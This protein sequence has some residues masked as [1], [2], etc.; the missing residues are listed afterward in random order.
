MKL[1]LPAALLGVAAVAN[2]S[3][4]SSAYSECLLNGT[5]G[6][7]GGLIAACKDSCSETLDFCN[8]ETG[9]ATSCTSEYSTCLYSTLTLSSSCVST[10]D[11][12]RSNVSG[13]NGDS[14]HTCN[15]GLA[16][17]KQNCGVLKDL[18]ETSGLFTSSECVAQ[19]GQCL[20]S[21]TEIASGGSCVEQYDVCRSSITG[22]DGDS[23]NQCSTAMAQ[24]KDECANR[25]DA[26]NTSGAFTTAQCEAQENSCLDNYPAQHPEGSDCVSKFYTC[27]ETNNTSVCNTELAACKEECSVE[28]DAALSSGTAN[29]TRAQSQYGSCLDLYTPAASGTDCVSDYR[30]CIIMGNSSAVCGASLAQCKDS[31]GEVYDTCNTS[32][33]ENKT[34]CLQQYQLCYD[35]VKSAAYMLDDCVTRF[36][37]SK[38][39]GDSDAFSSAVLADCKQECS[40]IESTCEASGDTSEWPICQSQY[41]GCL[42]SFSFSFSSSSTPDCVTSFRESTMSNA[43]DA[44]SSALLAT[45]KN[46]CSSVY[47]TCLSSGETKYEAACLSQY[48]SCLVSFNSTLFGPG[49]DC[50]S[51]M[52]SWK[53][54][55]LP[56]N[57]VQAKMATCKNDCSDIW[58][59]CLSSGDASL[60]EPCSDLNVKCLGSSSARAVNSTSSATNGTTPSTSAIAISTGITNATS[61][62]TSDL[63]SS[64]SPRISIMAAS[65]SV[66]PYAYKNVTASAS[67]TGPATVLPSTTITDV[68]YTTITTCPAGETLTSSGS[69]TVLST[70]SVITTTITSQSTITG[71]VTVFASSETPSAQATSTAT[72]HTTDYV[73]EVVY[74]TITTCP[75]GKT[76]TQSGST[77]VLTVPSVMT[78]TITYS[79]LVTA[80]STEAAPSSTTIY[81]TSTAYTTKTNTIT[82]T[83]AAGS[84][85]TYVTEV[86]TDYTT[87]CPVTAEASSAAASTAA[88][89]TAPI[90]TNGTVAA[91]SRPAW[92]PT[93]GRSG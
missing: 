53:S 7:C 77:T 78:S 15:A 3:S 68:I 35:D 66:A 8:K 93:A 52:S 87:I 30:R 41:Q 82:S 32:G 50:D 40:N 33:F 75:A 31:C 21:F 48:D 20:D 90:W 63:V 81:T 57:V 71:Y 58:S 73:T 24:C 62:S 38:A 79:S 22:A 83:D 47:S 9:N 88:A 17:C 13:F 25:L 27:R 39:N 60:K 74:T 28:Y 91:G 45:C 72:T 14:D 44:D 49:T 43:T 61:A 29:T 23:D 69:T 65:T 64:E 89:W 2:A 26:C 5:S 12:C 55:G 70:P 86:V 85:T 42:D 34:A 10:Y 67:S 92:A 4:C 16:E 80:T 1:L 56:D 6:G 84:T 19:Q 51:K 11:I 54:A 37:E 18:C 59:T 36:E 46:D 76:L